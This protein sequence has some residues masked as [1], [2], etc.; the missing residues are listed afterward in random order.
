MRQRRD[1]KAGCSRDDSKAQTLIRQTGKLRSAMIWQNVPLR[2][3]LA[4]SLV[5]ITSACQ[6]KS[7]VPSSDAQAPKLVTGLG[8]IQHAVSTANPQAQK[9]FDQGLAYLYAF[10][11]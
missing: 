7:A 3:L 10:N 9:Y 2:S 11:H 4:L 6:P 8:P 1:W 5:L